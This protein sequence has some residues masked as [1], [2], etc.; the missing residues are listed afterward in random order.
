MDFPIISHFAAII[1]QM[2]PPHRFSFIVARTMPYV[3]SQLHVTEDKENAQT[4]AIEDKISSF[5]LNS[6]G[7][8]ADFM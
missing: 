3:K 8:N 4:G 1:I 6:Y 2:F 5:R 7:L